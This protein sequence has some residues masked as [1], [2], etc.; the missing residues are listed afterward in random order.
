MKRTVVQA[1]CVGLLP[2][3]TKE[4]ST[5]NEETPPTQRELSM[6]EI[7]RRLGFTW[8]TGQ[9]ALSLAKT[10]QA[11]IAEG[12]EEGWIMLSEDEQCSKYTP[13][14]LTALEHWIENNEMVQHSPFKDSLIIKRGQS[15]HMV[16][17][18]TTCAPV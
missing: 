7:S 3:P 18:Q 16:R 13:E 5:D 1:M 11:D 10:K 14:L 6:Q 17:D 9:R 15:R 8:G 2:T 4:P 12:N